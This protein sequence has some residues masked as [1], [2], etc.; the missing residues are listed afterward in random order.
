MSSPDQK[1]KSEKDYNRVDTTKSVGDRRQSNEETSLSRFLHSAFF[2]PI[3]R[4]DKTAM[5][6][7]VLMDRINSFLSDEQKQQQQ[8]SH[9]CGHLRNQLFSPLVSDVHISI[10]RPQIDEFNLGGSAA[11][12]SAMTIQSGIQLPVID[13]HREFRKGY[14]LLMWV[15]L[16][17]DDDNKKKEKMYHGGNDN[18]VST[19][20]NKSVQKDDSSSISSFSHFNEEPDPQLLYRFATSASPMAHGVQATLHR[21]TGYASKDDDNDGDDDD[22]SNDIPVIVHV[23]TLRPISPSKIDN[24]HSVTLP[25]SLTTKSILIPNGQW[26]LICIQHSF[27]YLKRPLMSVS[28]NGV[29]IEKAEM[30]YPT[31]GG[32]T[33]EVMMDNYLLCNLPSW[34]RNLSQG[35]GE[36][37]RRGNDDHTSSLLN[38]SQVDFAGFGLFKESI[39]TLLQAIICEHGPCA[40]A[41]GVIPAVPPVVQAKDGIVVG[42]TA[43]Q[44]NLDVRGS[45]GSGGVRRSPKRS[46][47]MTGGPFGLSSHR[48]TSVSEGRGIGIPLC[49][50]V[51][52]TEEVS[53]KGDLIIQQLLSKLVLGLNGS[54]VF[55]FGDKFA[56]TVNTSCNIGIT[57]DAKMVGIVHPKPPNRKNDERKNRDSAPAPDNPNGCIAKCIGN[58]SIYHATERFL[59]TMTKSVECGS[60]TSP[61]AVPRYD[62]PRANIASLNPLPSLISTFISVDPIAYILQPFHLAL[63]PPG[64]THSLQQRLYH[65]SFDHLYDLVVFNG[66]ALAAKLIDLFATNLYLGGRMREEI[67]HR[68]VV[69]TLMLLLRRVL[70][71]ASRLG[72]LACKEKSTTKWL[73]QIYSVKESP[74]DENQDITGNKESAPSKV[75]SNITKACQSLITACCGPKIQVGKRWKRPLLPVHVRRTSDLAMTAIFGMVFDLDLWGGDVIAAATIMQEFSDLYCSDGF[76]YTFNPPEMTEKFDS[77]YGRLLRGQISVQHLLDLIRMRYGNEM[78]IQNNGDKERREALQSLSKS[79]SRI[80]YV[81]LKYSLFKQISL[82]EQDIYAIVGALSDCPLGSLGAHVVL[83]ALID[84]LVY[85]EIL[86]RKGSAILYKELNGERNDVSQILETLLEG[87][88]LYKSKSMNL[89]Q[90]AKLKRVKSEIAGRL[91]RNLLMGQF[92]DV[93]APMLLSRTVFDGRRNLI[94]SDPEQNDSNDMELCRVVDTKTHYSV[95]QWENHWMFT[96]QI[97]VVSTIIC[98]LYIK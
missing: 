33:G 60:F 83:S 68:G 61:I 45:G 28:V 66:G 96:L 85:C 41:D 59:D 79:L 53:H 34:E 29:E 16:H 4:H 75:P 47:G 82:G 62:I 26:T 38:V 97:F 80:L 95:F 6:K 48:I 56:F 76:E 23:E 89:E 77:G 51:Q 46:A 73:W 37:G 86:P 93:V 67:I 15:R 91:A 36:K 11:N 57:A 90:S 25:N 44:G 35:E 81:L 32:E 7:F 84:M 50:G 31:L 88:N 71:R 9:E 12:N 65:D 52:L 10:H 20:K 64:Y 17:N 55:K 49:A 54:D 1:E 21:D 19:E 63:P 92:H 42:S 98:M 18:D 27:P 78:I 87:S 40:S 22:D 74:N 13:W 70:L 72:I 3:V 5:E 39:P 30:A 58:I 43:N 24:L 2:Q 8:Q 14:S 94:D 69:H